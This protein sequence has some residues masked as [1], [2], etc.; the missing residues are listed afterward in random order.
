MKN[1]DLSSLCQIIV[2]GIFVQELDRQV[3]VDI[4]DNIPEEHYEVAC[5]VFNEARQI[6]FEQGFIDHSYNEEKDNQARK[7]VVECVQSQ[8]HNTACEVF[9][10]TRIAYF[11]LGIS[12]R[13][14]LRGA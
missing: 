13:K 5:E 2:D 14:L 12:T 4:L 6:Y 8:H 10:V 1:I 11:D 7:D 3:R 9:E